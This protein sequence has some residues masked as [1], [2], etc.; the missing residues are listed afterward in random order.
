MSSDV[1]AFNAR[2][3]EEALQLELEK[4][5]VKA[6]KNKKTKVEDPL[7]SKGDK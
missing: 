3:R 6:K 7:K 4:A 1:T 5:N 2:R